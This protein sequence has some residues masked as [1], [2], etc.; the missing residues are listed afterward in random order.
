MVFADTQK[1]WNIGPLESDARFV[2][3]T[4]DGPPSEETLQTFVLSEGSFLKCNGELK[5]AVE[6]IALS[7]EWHRGIDSTFAPTA[8][9]PT[10]EPDV[11]DELSISKGRSHS[12]FRKGGT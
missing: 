11:A 3:C 12:S 2:C 9:A 8:T 10:S 5:F 4:F 7:Y 1:S 6:K